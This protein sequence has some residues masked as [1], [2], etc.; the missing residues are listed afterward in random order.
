MEHSPEV[1]ALIA[2]YPSLRK[3]IET[4]IEFDDGR[5]GKVL[6]FIRSHPN[7]AEFRASPLTLL[8]AIDEF[9]YKHD[10][11]ISI[12]PHKADIVSKLVEN[13]KPNTVVE[14]GG[15]LGYSAILLA[16]VMKSNLQE[17]KGEIQDLKVWS[18]EM[19]PEF[20]DIARQLIELS[21]LSDIIAVVNGPAEDS[22]RKLVKDGDLKSVD[23]IFLDHVEEL[24]VQDF[25]ICQELGLLKSGTVIL[26]DNVVRPGAPEYR[27]LVRGLDG[28]RSEGVRG[29]IQPGDLEDELE[30]SHVL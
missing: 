10:F 2:K 1:Q 28:I 23:M 30:V 24:Y 8:A 6:N 12:G 29:L 15:Y 18:L 21:G 11:L 13:D 7:R 19:N 27:E 22:L 17:S 9:S 25:R 20:A 5:E 14:L 3:A 16:H 4:G 26:A